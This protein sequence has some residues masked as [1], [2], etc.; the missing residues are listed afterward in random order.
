MPVEVPAR[1]IEDYLLCPFRAVMTVQRLQGAVDPIKKGIGERDTP[2]QIPG[3]I[4]VYPGRHE[5]TATIWLEDKPI[6][7]R[8]KPDLVAAWARTPTSPVVVEITSTPIMGPRSVRHVAVRAQL[9]ALA[10][11]ACT[12]VAHTPLVVSSS[13][14]SR[15]NA[16]IPPPPGPLL[17]RALEG[18]LASLDSPSPPA[19]RPGPHCYHCLY[20][21][22]CPSGW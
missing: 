6:T 1:A 21:H 14:G 8:G 11:T 12:G 18:L 15:H 16:L 13:L 17:R 19:A 5:L 9:Y 7:V 4:L 3:D 10:A 20:R 22:Y 2:G